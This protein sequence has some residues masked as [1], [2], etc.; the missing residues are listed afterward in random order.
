MIGHTYFFNLVDRLGI[1]EAN[2]V[3][4]YW[5]LV[6]IFYFN[7]LFRNVHPGT[8]FACIVQHIKIFKTIKFELRVLRR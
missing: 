1:S 6:T 5:K 8:I 2:Y 4:A 3:G 7:P